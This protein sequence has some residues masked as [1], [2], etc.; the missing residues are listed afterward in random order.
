V[1]VDGADRDARLLGD[2]GDRRGDVAAL[3]DQLERRGD[4]PLAYLCL[5]RLGSLGRPICD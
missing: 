5:A 2:R 3:G 1:A 4:D